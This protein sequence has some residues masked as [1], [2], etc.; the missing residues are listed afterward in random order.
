MVINFQNEGLFR[1][2]KFVVWYII[3]I[4][5]RGYFDVVVIRSEETLR[6]VRFLLKLSYVLIFLD[7]NNIRL[8]QQDTILT[9]NVVSTFSTY[10]WLMATDVNSYSKT[11]IIKENTA[12]KNHI[13]S[14]FPLIFVSCTG[15]LVGKLQF[16]LRQFIIC[17]IMTWHN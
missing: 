3:F 9:R 5:F 11:I 7:L 14:R 12:S 1:S 16:L 8:Y 17:V 13:S 10:W 2:V 15:T 6:S 4:L